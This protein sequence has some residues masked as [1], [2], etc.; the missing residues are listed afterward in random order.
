[1]KPASIFLSLSLLTF[2][3]AYAASEVFVEEAGET[4]TISIDEPTRDDKFVDAYTDAKP[5]PMKVSDVAGRSKR[6]TDYS[7]EAEGDAYEDEDEDNAAAGSGGSEPSYE[8]E[9]RC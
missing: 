1:M 7:S 3:L 9:V 5:P 2:L 6:A 8:D 4:E